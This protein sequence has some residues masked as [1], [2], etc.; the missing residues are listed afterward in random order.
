MI[1]QAV[2]HVVQSAG[3]DRPAD[4]GEANAGRHRAEPGAEQALRRF[5]HPGRRIVVQPEKIDRLADDFQIAVGDRWFK[6]GG[7][8]LRI[9]AFEQRVEKGAIRERIEAF[10][11]AVI[12]LAVAE[13]GRTGGMVST[14]PSFRS[15]RSA[16]NAAS[17]RPCAR[18]LMMA[19]ADQVHQALE[20]G[21]C[22]P[23]P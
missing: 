21:A 5:R 4:R 6:F 19:G 10:D 13:D 9:T 1:A 17:A 3:V 22:P 23:M 2:E 12:R 14:V 7:N 16:R 11:G 15:A 20:P 18:V 8:R